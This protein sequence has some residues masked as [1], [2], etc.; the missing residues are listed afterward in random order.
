MYYKSANS[1]LKHWDF[2]L[3]DLVMLQMAYILAF[4][5][6]NGGRNPYADPVYLRTGIVLCLADICVVFFTEGY[7]GILRRGYF[8][9][10][11][12][13]AFHA[14]AVICTMLAYLFLTQEGHAFSRLV[15]I[16]FTA[17]SVL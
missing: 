3:L 17:F 14:A 5:L 12:A 11:K 6:R 13:V 1:W 7:R 9:E 2:I 15:F 4:G 8:R 16:Y 10:F